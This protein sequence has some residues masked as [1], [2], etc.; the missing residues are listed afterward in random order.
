M[1]AGAGQEDTRL[2]RRQL[3]SNPILLFFSVFN[4]HPSQLPDPNFPRTILL[5]AGH[6]LV[7]PIV[8]P[9]RSSRPGPL[10]LMQ[11]VPLVRHR[12]PKRRWVTCR[13]GRREPSGS[14]RPLGQSESRVNFR[15]TPSDFTLNEFAVRGRGIAVSISLKSFRP[16]F[17]LVTQSI[18]GDQS[19]R[20]QLAYDSLAQSVVFAGTA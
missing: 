19:N 18:S 14:R 12:K 8:L 1:G 15:N 4:P 10:Q 20:F 7:A 11:F 6:P 9:E 3:R 5:L 2:C 17:I 16:F 13:S